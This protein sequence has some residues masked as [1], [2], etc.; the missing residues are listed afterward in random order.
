[1]FWHFL[2]IVRTIV[3]IAILCIQLM[4]LHGITL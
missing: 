3:T 1:M 4:L 2:E